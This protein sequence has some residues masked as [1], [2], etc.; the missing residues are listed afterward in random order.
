MSAGCTISE[1]KKAE[2][3]YTPYDT[4]ASVRFNSKGVLKAL[5]QE[6]RGATRPLSPVKSVSYPAVEPI[7]PEITP[8]DWIARAW[9]AWQSMEP[10]GKSHYLKRKGLADLIIP[11]IRHAKGHI[12]VAI[13]DT[14]NS[15][16][17]LQRIFNDGQKRFTKGLAKK[18][19]FA[20]IGEASLPDKMSTIHVCEWVVTAISIHRS[21]GEPVISALDAFNIL[22]VS[23]NLK[24]HY[25][26][27]PIIIM[28]AII[29]IYPI[30]SLIAKTTKNHA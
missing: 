17:G 6:S 5:W 13:I 30:G 23:K 10:V 4:A 16:L 20:V 1:V 14:Q 21:I 29:S 12:R 25:P 7:K 22:P 27:T 26:K 3:T 19:N 24:R 9:D 18:G 28:N 8:I 2:H 15:F 11:G